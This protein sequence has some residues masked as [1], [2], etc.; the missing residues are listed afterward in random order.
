MTAGDDLFF[1]SLYLALLCRAHRA[2]DAFDDDFDLIVPSENPGQDTE[3][4]A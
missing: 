3:I 2:Q 4:L 1:P